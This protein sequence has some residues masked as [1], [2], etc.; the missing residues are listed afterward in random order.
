MPVNINRDTHNEI[1]LNQIRKGKN[2]HLIVM[3]RILSTHH[4]MLKATESHNK[5]HLA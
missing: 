1:K 5:T 3:Q 4:G 2:I